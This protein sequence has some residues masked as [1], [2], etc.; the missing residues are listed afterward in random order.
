[1][2]RVKLLSVVWADP[3]TRGCSLLLFGNPS[4]VEQVIEQAFGSQPSEQ[5]V[6]RPGSHRHATGAA[7]DA[8]TKDL[9]N[10]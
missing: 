2:F 3:S 6:W 10:D 4:G 7:H 8:K 1:M 9:Q 5:K